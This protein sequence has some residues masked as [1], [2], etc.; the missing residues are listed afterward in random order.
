MNRR[1]DTVRVVQRGRRGLYAS[2]RAHARAPRMLRYMFPYRPLYVM[3]PETESERKA[4][5]TVGGE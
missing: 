5:R 4:S 3:R 1:M 2:A